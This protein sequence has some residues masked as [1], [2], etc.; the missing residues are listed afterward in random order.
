MARKRGE[1]RRR[2]RSEAAAA[3]N[4]GSQEATAAGSSR[5]RRDAPQQGNRR[6]TQTAVTGR[7]RRWLIGGGVGAIAAVA[8]I[9]ALVGGGNSAS[10]PAIVTAYQGEAELGGHDIEFTSLL[11]QG[12]PVILNFWA[13]QC[14]PCRAEMPAFQ[15]LYQARRNDLLLVGV[16]VGP[17]L[18]LGSHDD[19]RQLLAELAI[20]YPTA[21][22][23]TDTLVRR[24]NV[25]AMPTT[26][27]FRGDGTIA[28]T[29]VGFLR[30]STLQSTVSA[31]L[32]FEQ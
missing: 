2:Q 3:V 11:G 6:R 1:R 4:R 30:E 5:R 18:R 12:Q 8:I 13:G 28:S 31:L 15:R 7:R 25:Q 9:F 23:Q 24:Y 22:A 16:D 17:F 29:H 20:T 27:F 21:F 26:V 32:A 14:P 19:A 10:G